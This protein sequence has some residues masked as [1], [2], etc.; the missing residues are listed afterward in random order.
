MPCSRAA[1][2]QVRE[3]W[4]HRGAAG[5]DAGAGLLGEI[6]GAEHEAGEPRFGVACR[7]RDR[8]H[9]EDRGRRF[10]HGPDAHLL[11]G[12]HAEQALRDQL[13]LL[14]GRDLRDQDGV[15]RSGG[16]RRQVVGKPRRV[17]A[18]GADEHLA[19]T[20][21]SGLDGGHHLL[22][23]RRLGVGR[24]RVLQVEDHAVRRKRLGL[25]QRAGV[26]PRHIEHA[27]ARTD[28][29]RQP[30]FSCSRYNP[31]RHALRMPPSWR[32]SSK[33]GYRFC[34]KGHAQGR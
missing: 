30:P 20:E 12:V 13:E 11:V 4:Q 7:R 9:V 5:H 23:R 33:S 8:P 19:R 15:G 2:R 29:H 31:S 27:A 17:E 34:D 25:L 16:R 26:R 18:V 6:V 24:D 28:G 22:A 14:G 3:P 10:D 21:P 1:S 32:M